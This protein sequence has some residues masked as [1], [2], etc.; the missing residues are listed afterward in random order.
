MI[1]EKQEEIQWTELIDDEN[2]NVSGIV[3]EVIIELYDGERIIGLGKDDEIVVK[4]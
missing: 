2:A 1:C 3:P 4:I